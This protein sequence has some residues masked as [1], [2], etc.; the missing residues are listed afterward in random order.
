MKAADPRTPRIYS[1]EYVRA[2]DG[3]TDYVLAFG[4]FGIVYAILSLVYTLES[5]T[6]RQKVGANK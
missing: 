1:W 3:K 4:M 6:K 5:D 2:V